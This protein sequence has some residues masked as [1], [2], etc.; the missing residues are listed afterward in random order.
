MLDLVESERKRGVKVTDPAASSW[1]GLAVEISVDY[2][3]SIVDFRP[4]H[5]PILRSINH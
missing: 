5:Y 4:S 1:I 2:M 3:L